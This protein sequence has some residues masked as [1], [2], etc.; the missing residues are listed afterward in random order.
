MSDSSVISFLWD[1]GESLCA[2]LTAVD[3][4]F[5]VLFWCGV[6]WCWFSNLWISFSTFLVSFKLSSSK[7]SSLV[8][9][10]SPFMA[11][12]KL[13]LTL[14]VGT[15]FFSCSMIWNSSKNY[16]LMTGLKKVLNHK[17]IFLYRSACYI[18]PW[19][20]IHSDISLCFH[21]SR[22]NYLT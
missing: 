16:V 12:A 1:L 10:M 7:P 22:K 4:P 14:S 20:I 5:R 2:S 18:A 15:S 17:H 21:I 3:V 13:L 11:P 19:Y 9:L 6:G 8:M